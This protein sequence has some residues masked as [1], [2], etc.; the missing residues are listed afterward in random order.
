MKQGG[1]CL[2]CWKLNI[3]LQNNI[4]QYTLL[5]QF[6]F[7]SHTCGHKGV[8]N[9][10]AKFNLAMH[11]TIDPYTFHIWSMILSFGGMDFLAN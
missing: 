6:F 5:L 1:K 11:H 8:P 10:V 7:S 4:L 3:N 9:L 2:I